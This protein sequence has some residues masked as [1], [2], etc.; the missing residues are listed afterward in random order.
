MICKDFKRF[1]QREPATTTAAERSAVRTHA[2][3][4]H[5]CLE[6]AD[7]GMMQAIK[8]L[9][10][11]ELAKVVARGIITRSIDALDPEVSP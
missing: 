10:L 3:V 2:R 9:P 6:W 1:F 4:C 11:G 8:K 5:K 7:A